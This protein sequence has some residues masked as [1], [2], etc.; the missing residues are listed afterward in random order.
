MLKRLRAI[1]TLGLW[2]IF[3]FL[4][5][6]EIAIYG[7]EQLNPSLGAQ[8]GMQ[9]I[10]GPRVW[11]I[12]PV[13]EFG[14]ADGLQIRLGAELSVLGG[15]A[16]TQLETLVL[17]NSRA[18]A[19]IYFGGGIGIAWVDD[20]SHPSRMQIPLLAL[21]GLKTRPIGLLTFAIEAVLLAPIGF[22]E[23]VTT[24]FAAGVLFS[25]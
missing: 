1:C 25:L 16:L 5:L 15:A 21:I 18:G 22:Q 2:C 14:P 8:I 20:L 19:R 10:G 9:D 4:A 24:R 13:A 7:A 6:S 3:A 17:M 23:G 11:I 12:G